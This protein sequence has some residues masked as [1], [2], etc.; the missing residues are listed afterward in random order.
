MSGGEAYVW[1]EDGKFEA[2]CNLGMVE[3]EKV[4]VPDD[5]QTLKAM[6]EDHARHTGSRKARM[7]LDSWSVM[8]PNFVKVMPLDYKRVLAER[9]AAM[10]K[11]TVQQGT[12]ACG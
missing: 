6:L 3:L 7:I 12:V 9:K 8:L 10:K 4:V 2:R 11:S 1:N 5:V